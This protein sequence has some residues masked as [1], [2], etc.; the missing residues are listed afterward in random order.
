MARRATAEEI[1]ASGQKEFEIPGMFDEQGE[2]LTILCRKVHAGERMS[3][4]PP[5]PASVLQGDPKLMAERER[6]WLDSLTDEQMTARRTEANEY[7]FRL[8][9]LAALEPKM[10]VEDARSLGDGALVLADEITK[11]SANEKR[12][13]VETPA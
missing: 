7:C 12:A 2:A 9:E 11:F 3:L 1:R 13:P 10:T 4:M 5:L 8:I 6:A